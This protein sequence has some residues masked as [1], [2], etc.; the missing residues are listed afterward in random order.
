MVR[1]Q[2]GSCAVDVAGPRGWDSG[3]AGALLQALWL[4]PGGLRPIPRA[5]HPGVKTGESGIL[6]PEEGHRSE[7][8]RG[9]VGLDV[10]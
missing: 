5:P 2:P 9:R 7:V 4:L 1:L 3:L 8:V 6:G 10:Y